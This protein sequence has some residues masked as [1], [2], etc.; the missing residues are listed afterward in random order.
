MPK[1]DADRDNTLGLP[2]HV[3]GCEGE[4]PPPEDEPPPSPLPEP[5]TSKGYTALPVGYN[6]PQFR[7]V[8]GPGF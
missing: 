4:P 5:V 2:L 7:S 8:V 6:T 1:K 3:L